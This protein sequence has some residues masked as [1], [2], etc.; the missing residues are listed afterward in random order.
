VTSVVWSFELTAFSTMF[1]VGYI[2]APPTVLTPWARAGA[3]MARTAEA[4]RAAKVLRM[5][6]SL[7]VASRIAGTW[8]AVR[9]DGRGS[10]RRSFTV[11]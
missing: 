8:A 7:V 10:F 9:G 4:A 2:G 3:A 5:R 11:S 1:F 6:L